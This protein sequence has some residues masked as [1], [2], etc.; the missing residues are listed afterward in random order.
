MEHYRPQTR[1]G[2]DRLLPCNV[3]LEAFNPALTDDRPENT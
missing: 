2:F 3:L 1:P